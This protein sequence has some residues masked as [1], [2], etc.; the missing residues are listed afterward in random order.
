MTCRKNRCVIIVFVTI[1]HMIVGQTPARLIFSPQMFP[2]VEL[3]LRRRIRPHR[4]S[5]E[6][7]PQ[8]DL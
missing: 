3:P 2:I 7:T 6:D 4:D 5:V 1:G 8:S